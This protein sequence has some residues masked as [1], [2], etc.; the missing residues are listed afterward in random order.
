MLSARIHFRIDEI[1]PLEWNALLQDNNPFLRHEFLYALEEHGCVGEQFGWLP[2]H[3]A[4]YEVGHLIGAMPLYEKANSY[5]E[6]VF[7]HAWADAYERAGLPYFPKLVSAVPYTPATG[8]RL[9]STSGRSADVYPVLLQVV[10]ELMQKNGASGYHCLFPSSENCQYLDRQ[11]LM[12]RHDCQFHWHNSGYTSFSDFLSRLT[13]RKRK[14]IRQERR[15][16][17]ESGVSIR[18][19]S[20]HQATEQDWLNFIR[21]YDQTFEEKWG[22]A[23]LNEAFFRQVGDQLPD[24]VLLVLADLHGECIAGSLMYLSDTR[25][26]GRYWGSLRY[27]NSLHFEACYYQGIEYCIEHGLRIFEPGAQGEHKISRG[28]LPHLT[29][30]YH[31]LG[32]SPFYQSIENYVRHERQAVSDYMRQM[33]KQSPYRQVSK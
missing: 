16:V 24:Q 20:G 17:R 28:F 5:G 10:S 1:P 14:K 27:V 21:F 29:R 32:E 3:I 26:Y 11:S 13:S 4:V 15:R 19:L 2:C 18:R 22:V 25:L 9:L 31:R 6:F 23:T 33:E 30:S 12:V 8:Q 7:D